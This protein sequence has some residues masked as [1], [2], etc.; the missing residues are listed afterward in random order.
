MINTALLI[1]DVQVA[2]FSYENAK[3]YKG[4]EVLDNIKKVLEAARKIQM[5]VIFIQHTENEEYT[6]GLPTWEICYE[7][8]PLTNEIVVEKSSCDSFHQTEL[9]DI[10]QKLEI[11]NLIIMGMQSEFCIDTSCRRAFSLGYKNIL[12][13]DAH[14][15]FD[16]ELLTAEQIVNF[17]NRVLGNKPDGRFV[18]LKSANEVID[19][20][21]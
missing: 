10:L 20:L 1:I 12:I 8:A 4:I 2:M 7:V 5:P 15:T 17:E 19:L 11:K 3:L 13:E 18:I 6:K 16:S 14:S 21:Y 9:Q